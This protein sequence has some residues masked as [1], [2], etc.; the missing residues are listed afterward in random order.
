MEPEWIPRAENEIADYISRIVDYD[1]WS[2]NPIVFNELDRQWGPHTVDR[3]ANGCNNQVPRFN[4]RYYC[5]GA[6]AI[7]AF[8]CDWGHDTNWWC[9]PLFLVPRLLKHA[10]VTRAKGTL[11]IPRWASAPF[12]PLIFPDGVNPAEFVK[13][14]KELPRIEGLFIEGHSGCNLFKGIPNTPVMALRLSWQ[15]A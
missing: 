12:W 4:A 13:E 7:D 2:L 11:I 9:P 5:P 1:D 10:R 6:E 3:F 8:T 14:I 15:E